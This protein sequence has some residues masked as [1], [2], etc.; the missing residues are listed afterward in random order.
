M[1]ELTLSGVAFTAQVQPDG[2]LHPIGG[3]YQKLS[4][5]AFQHSFP[6]IHTVVVAK[7]QPLAMPGLVP[8]RQNPQILT[9]P[10]AD[11]HVIR[12][13][14]VAEA[15]ALL[16]VDAQTRWGDI[17]DCAQELRDH[18]NLVGREWLKER[19]QKF[20]HDGQRY[21][22]YFLISGE[23]G[24]G[25]SAFVA[26]RLRA[27][28]F[29]VYHFIKKGRGAWDN[30][31]AF[32]RSLTAQLRRKYL[33]PPTDV[34]KKLSSYEKFA[35]ELYA[36][37]QR[38]S[39]SLTKGQRELLWLD[40]LDETYGPTGRFAGVALPGP[41]HARLPAGIFCVLTSRPGEHLNWLADPALCEAV[42][43]EDEGT[44]NAAD[45]RAYF[46]ACNRAEGLGLSTEFI[47][48]AVRRSENN[49]LFA[50]LLVKDLRALKPE[51][52]I[53]DRIPAG[54]RGWMVKQLEYVVDTWQKLKK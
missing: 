32:F 20:T 21:S 28:E 12:A 25:K 47:A 44:A 8:D 6:R 1:Q 54:L 42:R 9:D 16:A 34:E 40:G 14:T 4:K 22:G 27:Q 39:S 10:H 13:G 24:A 48:E 50:V 2:T 31:D 23:P 19:V 49:F 17:I 43:L 33:L 30:P 52:R 45:L 7:D 53:P 51:E 35:E 46:E 26:D 38:V 18:P 36:V 37:L 11:F 5:A 29:P 15:T 41:L 3:E